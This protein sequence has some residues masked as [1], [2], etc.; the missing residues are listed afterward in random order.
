MEFA[1]SG[2][3]TDANGGADG[4]AG[5]GAGGGIVPVTGV[6]A[7]GVMGAGVD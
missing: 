4:G 2:G 3:V 7:A 6:V 5:G 1:G